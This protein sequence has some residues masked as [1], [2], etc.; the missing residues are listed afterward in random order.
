MLRLG[1]L[2]GLP[3]LF[4]IAHFESVLINFD[5]FSSMLIEDSVVDYRKY[6][7]T[8]L[9]SNHNWSNYFLLKRIFIKR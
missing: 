7:T 9:A 1:N 2:I 3:S 6:A 8:F 4:R 5:Q